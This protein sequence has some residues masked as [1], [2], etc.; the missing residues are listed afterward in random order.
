M[1]V[2]DN[3]NFK[4]KLVNGKK[5]ITVNKSRLKR[6]YER[7]I[8]DEMKNNTAESSPQHEETVIEETP[9]VDTIAKPS[10]GKTGKR[11]NKKQAPKQAPD[12]IVEQI[13]VQPV[14]SEVPSAESMMQQNDQN[15]N[16]RPKRHRV[17]PDRYGQS[18]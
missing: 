12:K 17:A 18:K 6:C 15:I 8:L 3:A 10:K 4:V 11:K 14:T 7:K 5:T 13:P 16:T 9:I 1:E 2:I